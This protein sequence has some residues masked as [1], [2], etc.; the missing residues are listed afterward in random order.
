MHYAHTPN[1]KHRWHPLKVHLQG[2]ERLSRTFSKQIGAGELGRLAGIGH[3]LG[4]YHPQFQQYLRQCQD[5]EE[6]GRSKPPSYAPHAIYGAAIAWNHLKDRS[7]LTAQILA[8]TLYGHHAGIPT[9]G[10]PSMV[11]QMQ[12]INPED[13]KQVK[14][15][16]AEDFPNWLQ[17]I[18]QIELPPFLNPKAGIPEKMGVELFTRLL[19]S[20]LIDAD[21]INTSAHYRV[22]EK[23]QSLKDPNLLADQL[24][25]HP[26]ASILRQ[27]QGKSRVIWAQASTRLEASML[28]LVQRMPDAIAIDQLPGLIE[29]PNL[30]A[31]NPKSQI[32]KARWLVNR[33][34][35]PVVLT[36]HEVLLG[37]LFSN[38]PGQCRKLRQLVNSIIVLQD[39]DLLPFDQLERIQSMMNHL[40]NYGVTLIVDSPVTEVLKPDSPYLRHLTIPYEIREDTGFIPAPWSISN[41]IIPA[42]EIAQCVRDRTQ[43]IVSDR[44]FKPV[45][46]RIQGDHPHVQVIR[47]SMC[48]EQ[49]DQ[50]LKTVID[51]L[52][53]DKPCCLV[54]T[55]QTLPIAG[56]TT[57]LVE[58]AELTIL[59][60]LTSEGASIQCFETTQKSKAVDETRLMLQ[61]NRTS[62]SRFWQ[63]LDGF[64]SFPTEPIGR[65]PVILADGLLARKTISKIQAEGVNAQRIQELHRHI[66][67]VTPEKFMMMKPQC[68]EVVRGLWVWQTNHF[69][70]NPMV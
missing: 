35:S 68:W 28:D 9:I 17:Q 26:L 3:D 27:A 16:A 56:M 58:L 25:D 33:W 6:N 52:E 64:Q 24:G 62:L 69:N 38:Q 36:T 61:A 14:E 60:R 44:A 10:Q 54:T 19:M 59:K 21:Y 55:N 48:Q 4:K 41:A 7:P 50:V 12:H 5:A 47:P 42:K 46:K 31:G 40:T 23:G 13:I 30:D 51:A 11:L 29:I 66:M 32:A 67:M 49:H 15:A 53:Q 39:L 20:C 37:S 65:V 45:L 34:E 57:V 70:D 8:S 1:Q 2:V 63:R 22:R 43:I 18:E